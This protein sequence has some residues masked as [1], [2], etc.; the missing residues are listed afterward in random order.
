MESAHVCRYR[1]RI[2]WSPWQQQ[3][4]IRERTARRI[5]I[6]EECGREQAARRPRVPIFRDQEAVASEE[7]PLLD[8]AGVVVA[9]VFASH[10]D[11]RI[12]EMPARGLL[13]RMATRGVTESGAEPWLERF[14]RAGL[15]RLTW[16]ESERRELRSVNVLDAAALAELAHPGDRAA[17]A[18]AIT[19]A[20]ALLDGLDHPLVTEA[21]SMLAEEG[22][23]LS[24]ELARALAAV[25]RH[26][27]LG[28]VLAERVF[29]ARHLGSSKALGHLRGAIERRLGR[30]ER[31][32]IREGGALT[33][34]GGHGRLLI[35][36]AAFDLDRLGP[37]VGLSRETV[38]ALTEIAAPSSGLVAVENLTVFEA[39]CRGEVPDLAGAMYVWT[40]GY[41]GRGVRAVVEA[42]VRAGAFIRAWCDL[43]LDGTRI[44]RI[45]A[46]WA[47]GCG[48]Y[49][50]SAA[51]LEGSTQGQPLTDRARRAIEREL[52]MGVSDDLSAT[53]RASLA[54][55]WWVE[56]EAILGGVERA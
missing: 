52:Q 39:C 10:S 41:P 42:A 46:R 32:G 23:R 44:A 30:L 31:L 19:S 11:G 2:V 33:L 5:P 43:D 1:D 47:R 38:L 34:V 20:L 8:E 6:C 21:R 15:I 3:G 36:G 12:E 13:G 56:Q 22:P 40:A 53:L 14:M 16:R 18:E 24:A 54:V 9:E 27:A 51:E 29:S 37:Y 35:P 26:A 4:A 28:E 50:M 45:I 55:G 49:R 25:A 17:R 48:Y 7:L